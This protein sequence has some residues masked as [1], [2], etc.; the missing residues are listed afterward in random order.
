[1]ILSAE[2][3]IRKMKPGELDRILL[4]VVFVNEGDE[5]VIISTYPLKRK[6][7]GGKK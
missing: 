1:M 2:E 7:R 3:L 5:M 4:K 6:I